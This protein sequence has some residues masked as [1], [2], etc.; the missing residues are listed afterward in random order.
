MRYKT[1]GGSHHPP[2][3]TGAGGL[4]RTPR[5]KT[6]GVLPLP[7]LHAGLSSYVAP[8]F[9]GRPGSVE[10]MPSSRGVPRGVGC[11]LS[12]CPSASGGRFLFLLQTTLCASTI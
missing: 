8:V 2:P 1:L 9:K 10:P 4:R 11:C 7:G 3:P 12:R 6:R 5:C